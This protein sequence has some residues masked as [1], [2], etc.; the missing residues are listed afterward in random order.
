MNASTPAAA[1]FPAKTGRTAE[2]RFIQRI[3]VVVDPTAE[4][5]PCIEKAARIAERYGSEVELFVCDTETSGPRSLPFAITALEYRQ[6]LSTRRLEML[7]G[8]AKPLRNA[9]LKV[10]ITAK[11]H[12]SLTD[13]I[14]MHAIRSATD[15]VVKDTHPH[16]PIPH[17]DVTNTDVTLIRQLPSALL[18]VRAHPWSS[19]PSVAVAVDPCQPAERSAALDDALLDHAT[20]LSQ[21]FGGRLS[22][23]HALRNAPHLPERPVEPDVKERI[24]RESRATVEALA[25]GRRAD[26]S[27][28]FP[29]GP[30][31]PALLA[32]VQQH[33]PDILVMGSAARQRWMNSVPGGTAVELL[34]HLQ[35][36]L[37]VVK[38][39][40]FVSSLLISD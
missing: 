26:P 40:G 38:Q 8:L 13:G 35:C 4:R 32:F 31:R 20:S 34:E 10:A 39:P 9:G 1:A 2:P 21:A 19:P 29:R 6:V 33:R 18:L 7:E 30:T 24:D 23:V 3:L 14:G 37:W 12:A 25:E 27:F 17:S 16:L 28:F 5:H 11:W 22:V 36:D 15:L